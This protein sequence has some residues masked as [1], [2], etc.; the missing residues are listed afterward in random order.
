MMCNGRSLPCGYTTPSRS[1][2]GVGTR[3]DRR[4]TN[5]SAF[6]LAFP[7]RYHPSC[8]KPLAIRRDAH[9]IFELCPEKDVEGGLVIAESVSARFVNPGDHPLECFEL[10]AIVPA[11]TTSSFCKRL[12][13]RFA[14]KFSNPLGVAELVLVKDEF[15]R[16]PYLSCL[17]F[18]KWGWVTLE[19]RHLERRNE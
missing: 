1:C 6:P 19:L 17:S 16:T 15:T 8:D 9:L 2:G 18:H 5:C 7:M 12:K 10:P 14:V 13:R 11:Q 3:S 4:P